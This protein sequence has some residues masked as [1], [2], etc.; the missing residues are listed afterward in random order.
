MKEL[1]FPKK[2]VEK[3]QFLHKKGCVKNI[4]FSE[5]TYQVEV[6]DDVLNETFWPFIQLDEVGKI[7][8]CFCTC[9]NAEAHKTCEHLSAALFEIYKGKLQPLHIRFRDSLWSTLMHMAAKRHGYEIE[10]LKKMQ[11]Y[12]FY[13]QSSTKKRLFWIKPLTQDAEKHLDD[14]IYNRIIETEETSLKFSNLSPDEITLWKEGRPSHHLQF[15][16]SFWSDLA[17][18][19]MALYEGKS[20]CTITFKPSSGA[21]PKEIEISFPE[22][23]LWFYI[24]EVNWEEL[25]PSLSKMPIAL[26]IYELRDLVIDH[27]LYD[28]QK[29]TFTLTS[30]KLEEI[31]DKISSLENDEKRVV[32]GDW[33]FHP[34]IGFF[35]KEID[36]ILL[37]KE[38]K[39]EGVT[40]LLKKHPLL[41]E[42]YL[43][44]ARIHLGI[45][46]VSYDLRF[47]DLQRF[48]IC[49]YLFEKKDLQKI[50]SARFDTWVFLEDKGF[51]QLGPLLF[52]DVETI[53]P[54]EKVGEFIARHRVWLNQYEGFQTHLTSIECH[55]TYFIDSLERLQFKS[56]SETFDEAS[57]VLD[58]K[59]WLFIK[60]R[61][62]YAKSSSKVQQILIPGKVISREEISP[63]IKSNEEELEQIQ[64]FF[65]L[66]QP[67]L[68]SGLD[69][70]L[71]EK[72]EICLKP[73]HNFVKGYSESNV[74]FFGEFS[75]V[76]KEGFSYLPKGGSIPYR[77]QKET[78]IPEDEEEDFIIKDLPMLRP[79]ILSLDPRL[80]SPKHL[81]LQVKELSKLQEDN[82]S[83]WSM[84]LVYQSEYGQ[85]EIKEIYEAIKKHKSIIK[86]KAGL[87][88]L[89]D[90]RFNWVRSLRSKQFLTEEKLQLTSL[91]WMRLS[92]YEKI[93]PPS[94][95]EKN[96][97]D[98]IQYLNQL[99]S[100]QSVETINLDGLV[101]D[102]RPYQILGVKWLFFLFLHGL[103]GLLCDE[104]GLGKTHQ[105]M[106]LLAACM[107]VKK[108]GSRRFLVICPTSVIYHWEELLKKFLPKAKVLV[109]YGIQRS[110]KDFS[111]DTDIL[112]TSYG[113]FRSE[114]EVLSQ[115]VFDV[116]IFDE[117]QVAKNSYS[118]THKALKHLKANMKLGLTGTPI[119]NRILELHALFDIVLPNYLP[120]EAVYKELFVIPI[121]KNQDKEKIQLLQKL[122]QTFVLRRKKEEVLDDLPE[123]TEEISYVDL[124]DQQK[125]LYKEAFE[126]KKEQIYKDMKDP[127][128]PVPYLHIFALFTALKQICDHPALMKKDTENYQN[129]QSGKWDLFVELLQVARESGQKVVVFSQYLDML[130]IIEK[131]LQEQNIGY[132]QIRG[133]TKNRKEQMHRFRDDPTCEVFIGSLQAAG[134][135]IDLISASVVIHYDRW[136]NPAKENQA[137]DRVHRI[138]QNRG[139]QVFKLVSKGTIE[140]YIHNIIERKL[141][142]LQNVI[143][144]DD[145]DQIKHLNREEILQ[146]LDQ[147]NKA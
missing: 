125:Q 106:A 102:L 22:V 132:A 1:P 142:L 52:T 135:G 110:L 18:W 8:D 127:D 144:Y 44:N 54:Q 133:S 97:Q 27:I 81:V 69:I 118:Q 111:D 61:G 17:K 129:Y 93:I 45:C 63:F 33:I 19:L 104:M 42:K 38:V 9:K 91:E 24:S 130:D 65:S 20:E 101:S 41:L 140:E 43:E 141:S 6:Y 3:G 98:T 32:I 29:R 79:L 46:P 37:Q 143:G 14:L 107:N 68:K 62:F 117:L 123:K 36:P 109:F 138:G 50:D 4:I 145:Q 139:V 21:L 49:A 136:W 122:V 71:N 100:F 58:L 131:Y 105:A 80:K 77:F 60:G 56:F 128:Q 96:A 92:V 119:E 40:Y 76:A 11:P 28:K 31:G 95:D 57:G 103:S 89:D 85:V 88:H 12:G 146:I 74:R 5:G 23:S 70:F 34:E 72:Q 15:E 10:C 124:S 137:T 90:A 39:E 13:A 116:A 115:Y 51:Y 73:K 121:E 47:D 66:K 35:P 84:G 147:I 59:E 64:G 113:T 108:S 112:V 134:V 82:Y 26:P 53:I 114:K 87:L 75:F 25:I 2:D 30:H 16:L 86:T 94:R 99:C 7:S 55:L 83:E 67:V 48:H 78:C 126:R 120:S